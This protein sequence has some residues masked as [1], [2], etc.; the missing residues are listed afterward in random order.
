M[1]EED[2][3]GL[4]EIE[5]GKHQNESEKEKEGEHNDMSINP[6]SSE[7]VSNPHLFF[8]DQTPHI[9]L[10][11]FSSILEYCSRIRFAN[12]RKP[13]AYINRRWAYCSP[14]KF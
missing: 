6:R 5:H 10:I 8:S 3:E 11:C 7:E 14:R 12:R 2:Q 9:R 4:I 13:S 1:E